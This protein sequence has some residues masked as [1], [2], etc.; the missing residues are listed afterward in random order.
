MLI[1]R[2]R[3]SLHALALRPSPSGFPPVELD[4]AMTF[5]IAGLTTRHYVRAEHNAESA[6]AALRAALQARD[7]LSLTKQEKQVISTKTSKAVS[8][9]VQLEHRCRLFRC[10][11]NRAYPAAQ[12]VSE[13]W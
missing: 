12:D 4:L 13:S 10:E 5:C 1:F 3:Y 6:W 7:G 11:T 9:L 2:R 8:L